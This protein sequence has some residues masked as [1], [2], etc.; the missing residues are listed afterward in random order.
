MDIALVGQRQCKVCKLRNPKMSRPHY[1]Q[2][3]GVIENTKGY[4]FCDQRQDFIGDGELCPFLQ[5]KAGKLNEYGV[6]CKKCGKRLVN[7]MSKAVKGKAEHQLEMSNMTITPDLYGYRRN[8]EGKLELHCS[9][10]GA[11]SQ[12]NLKKLGDLTITGKH[13]SIKLERDKKEIKPIEIY[14][15]KRIRSN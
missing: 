10:R 1:N 14:D 11:D 4:T 2:K 8:R 15:K 3:L 6:Y 9:C 12:G 5:E 13:F 7:F